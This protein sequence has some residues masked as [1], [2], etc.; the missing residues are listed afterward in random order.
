MSRLPRSGV[1]ENS[2]LVPRAARPLQGSWPRGSAWVQSQSLHVPAHSAKAPPVS[3]V[4]NNFV[5]RN[6]R[7]P[8][9]VFASFR[10]HAANR[11]TT[12]AN[13]PSGSGSHSNTKPCDVRIHRIRR[14]G[15]ACPLGSELAACPAVWLEHQRSHISA[16]ACCR[17]CRAPSARANCARTGRRPHDAAKLVAPPFGVCVLTCHTVWAPVIAFRV[18]KQ[19]VFCWKIRRCT[20]ENNGKTGI[21]RRSTT[22]MIGKHDEDIWPISRLA[23]SG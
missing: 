7:R 5:Y 1:A 13:A 6:G 3:R 16:G 15:Q 4:D 19:S 23:C 11:R 22:A 20:C 17:Q 9:A 21:C 12:E 8:T 14:C 18:C 10:E 2:A